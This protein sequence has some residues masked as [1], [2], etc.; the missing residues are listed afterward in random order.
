[1]VPYDAARRRRSA[2]AGARAGRAISGVGWIVALG[3]VVSMAAVLL[4]FQYGQPRI[5]FAMARDGLL[6]AWAARVDPKTRIP[7]VDDA[8]HRRRRR[9]GV[10][11]RRRGRDLRPDQHRDAV[12]LRAGLRRRAGAARQGAGPP[13]AVQGAVRL[14]RSRRSASRRACS[15]WSGL[16]VPGVGA[17]RHLARHRRR[18]CYGYRHATTRHSRL[19]PAG[20]TYEGLEFLPGNSWQ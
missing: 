15:S 17:L 16:P 10:A 7:Y 3:A 12:R 18:H 6:P 13:A 20:G 9:A 8:G 19:A 5:F 14:G 11:R 2:G 4:V 1:M